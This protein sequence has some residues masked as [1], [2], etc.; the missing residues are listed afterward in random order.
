MPSILTVSL[1]RKPASIRLKAVAVYLSQVS[2]SRDG[3]KAFSIVDAVSEKC[4]ASPAALRRKTPPI[5][6]AL[7]SKADISAKSDSGTVN[8]P[9]VKKPGRQRE[10]AARVAVELEAA[11]ALHRAGIDCKV[12]KSVVCAVKGWSRATLYRRI[13]EESFPKPIKRDRYS[14]W[15]IAD[16]IATP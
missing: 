6:A 4:P 7:A 15:R 14:E 13:A 8:Q 10:I 12:K 11:L 2:N 16:V 9:V 5:A 3:L 1:P